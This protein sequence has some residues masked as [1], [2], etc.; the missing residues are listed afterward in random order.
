MRHIRKPFSALIL[1]ALLAAAFIPA[2]ADTLTVHPD[3]TLHPVSPTLYG[4]FLEDINCAVDG[5]LYAELLRNRSFENESLRQPRRA[6][7]WEAWKAA[8]TDRAA[9]TLETESPLHENDPTYL[10]FTLEEGGFALIRNQGFGGNVFRGGIPIRAGLTYDFSM[11]LRA[12]EPALREG[13][14]TVSLTD[15]A[16]SSLSGEPVCFSLS[17][18]P[19]GEWTRAEA[20]LTA[21]QTGDAVLCVT[22]EAPQGGRVDLDLFSLMPFERVGRDWPGGGMRADLVEALRALRPRFLRFPGG[23]VVEGTYVRGNAYY[24]KLTVGS[25]P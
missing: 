18:L 1:A 16:G 6:D 10:R 22:A 11:W 21:A 14:V 5:G 3:R 23:C 17:S 7:H 15:A 2:R 25:L 13:L 24:L 12:D 8:R 19:A 9:A 20:V 4:V